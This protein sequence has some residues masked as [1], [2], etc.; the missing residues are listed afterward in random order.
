MKKKILILAVLLLACGWFFLG[1]GHS[2]DEVCSVQCIEPPCAPGKY[3]SFGIQGPPFGEL[4]DE[5]LTDFYDY[6]DREAQAVETLMASYQY[7][8][9]IAG[10]M[11][12]GGV[13][14]EYWGGCLLYR[15]MGYWDGTH[16]WFPNDDGKWLAYTPS[17]GFVEELRDV[18]KTWSNIDI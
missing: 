4:T 9:A 8:Q 6:Y 17:K 11:P 18:L 16:I 12:G 3:F 2:F 14:M 15:Y 13:I 1:R 10:R 5:E 7:R